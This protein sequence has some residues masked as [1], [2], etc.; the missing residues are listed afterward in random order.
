MAKNRKQEVVKPR[1]IAMFLMRSE[2][3]YSYPGIGDKLG[4][5]DHTT[6]IHAYEK[7]IKAL[8]TDEKLNEE[9][10]SLKELLYA[11]S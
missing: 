6:A 10:T 8:E 1:Q 7:I 5:R 3:Q 9:I 11:I 4:G 2:L